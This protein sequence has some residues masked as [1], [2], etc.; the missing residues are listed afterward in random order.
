MA[1]PKGVGFVWMRSAILAGATAFAALVAWPLAGPA[2]ALGVLAAGLALLLLRHLANLAA[3]VRWL[4]HPSPSTV[5]EGSGV[6]DYV[7]STLY[8]ETRKAREQQHRLTAVL[9]RFRAAARAMPDGVVILN[10][11]NQIEWANP[12]AE[13]QFAID[14][15]KDGGQPIS[16]LVRNPEFVAF[17]ARGEWGEPLTLRLARG[18][19]LVLSIR[20]VPYGQDEKLLLVRDVTRWEKLET[21]RRDFVANV[22]HELKTPLTVLSGFLETLADGTV[23]AGSPQGRRALALMRDQSERMLRLIEDLL[24]LST[25]ESTSGPA[26]EGPV[27][28]GPLVGA[29]GEEARALSGGRHDIQVRVESPAIVVGNEAELRSAFGNLVSNAVRYTPE[30]G[31]VTLVWW[32]RGAEGV[33]TVED[34]G[35]GIEAEHIPRLTERFYRVDRS[36]SRETGGT[37]LGL[38]IV[39]HVLTRHQATLEIESEPGR[40]SRFSVVFPARR[41][42]FRPSAAAA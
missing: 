25:L 12:I 2:W 36:R 4:D 30:G 10:E 1:R 35:I 18:E 42:R 5:P 19:E 27:E 41:V 29:L 15:E 24:T 38:A 16:N 13:Q 32:R 31:R 23:P 37:G 39:K 7:F 33:F 17:L 40:G 26:S 22:S 3:L 6:W 34:T 11:E 20:V 21:M 28:V 9:V 8:R 14:L